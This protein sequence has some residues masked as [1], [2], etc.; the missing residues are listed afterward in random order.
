MRSRIQLALP[1]VQVA[2]AGGL[3]AEFASPPHHFSIEKTAWLL[4]SALNAPAFLLAD[5][6]LYIFHNLI[7]W[8]TIFETSIQLCFVWLVWYGVTI[9]SGGG[10]QS[11]LTSKTRARGL[12]DALAI[13]FGTGVGLRLNRGPTMPVFGIMQFAWAAVIIG[14]YGHDLWVTIRNP[15]KRIKQHGPASLS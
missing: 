9:E 11:V 10:G 4:C 13:I 6:P 12:V 15:R 2:L 5:I 8:D 1:L 14:F 3:L 7:G